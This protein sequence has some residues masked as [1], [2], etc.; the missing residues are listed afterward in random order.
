MIGK[1]ILKNNYQDSNVTENLFYVS[2]SD[3]ENTRTTISK[4][5]AQ[6]LDTICRA[7]NALTYGGYSDVSVDYNLSITEWLSE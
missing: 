3:T 1:V 4:E 5:Q 6:T 7:I 2:T